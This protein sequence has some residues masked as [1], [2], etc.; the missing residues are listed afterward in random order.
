MPNC[1]IALLE[2]CQ[3]KV[4]RTRALA[5]V[6]A[7]LALLCQYYDSQIYNQLQY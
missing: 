1:V 3:N 2:S 6:V 5:T 4:A 7:T